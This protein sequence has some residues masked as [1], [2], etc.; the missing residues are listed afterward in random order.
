M[1][2]VLQRCASVVVQ[3]SLQEGF[4]VTATEAMWKRV[5][6]LGT[7]A[8]GLRMQIRDGL[9]GRINPEPENPD[10]VAAHLDAMLGSRDIRERLGAAAQLRVYDEF[11]IFTEVRKIL[12][13][14]SDTVQNSERLRRRIA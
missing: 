6:V 14:L 13:L 10:A 9:G 2:N 8:C 3:N 4:G 7:R 12:E 1:V 5:P 11:L